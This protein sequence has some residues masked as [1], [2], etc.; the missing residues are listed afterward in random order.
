MTGPHSVARILCAGVLVLVAGAASAQVL[1]GEIF[2]KVSD[3]TDAVLPGATVTIAGPALIKPMAV[4]AASSG[5]YRFPNVPVGTYTM[6]FELPGFNK[7]VREGIIVQA[8]RNV[9]IN[10][11]LNLSTLEETVTITGASPVVDTKSTTLGVNFG[12]ELLEAIPTARDPWVII[13]QTPGLVMSANNVGGRNSGQ[14]EGYNAFGSGANK[15]WSMDGATVT[16]MASNSAPTYYDF[17]M[18]EEIQIQTGGMDASQ[19]SGGVSVNMVTRSGG[20]QLKGSSR[21]YTVDQRV[22]SKNAP[23]EVVAQGG[24]AG[25]PLKNN[26]EYGVEVG[27][28]IRRN[29]A[30]FWGSASNQKV[31]VGILGFLRPGAPA[32][33]SDIKDLNDDITEINNQSAKLQY[34]WTAAQ[35]STFLFQRSDK[36]RNARGASPTVALESTS[37]QT[38]PT[39]YF[40]YNHQW[41]VN[42]RLMLSGQGLFNGGGFLLNYH[43]DE[44]ATVQRLNHETLGDSRSGT[45][46]DNHRPTWEGR[47]DGNYFLAGFLGGDHSTKFGM[48]YRLTPVKTIS[49]TGGGATVRLRNNGDH[50]VNITRDGYVARDTWQWS[51]YFNDSWKMGRATL[52]W[53]LR[54]DRQDDKALAAEID[55]N[56]IL[57]DL[58]PAVGF[59]GADAGVV[60]NDIAPRLGFPYDLFGNTR[61]IFKA[62]AGR[63]Y[64][65]GLS[66]STDLS[67]TG[68]TTLS[69]W[70][71]DRNGD[72]FAQ[73][74]EIEF[75][76]GFRSTPTSNYD[77]LNPSAVRTPVKVDP[78]IENDITDEFITGIDHELMP[79]F[80]VGVSYVY[81]KYHNFQESFRDGITS[82]AYFHSGSPVTFTRSCGNALCDE[83]SYTGTYYQ[84]T[85]A[86]PA[87][88]TTRMYGGRTVYHGIEVT[89]RKRF[90]RNW[91]LNS[92]FSFNNTR[93]FDDVNTFATGTSTADPTNYELQNGRDNAG[94]NGARWLGKIAGMYALPW[95]MSMSAFYNVREGL[96]FNRTIQSPSRTG[97]GGTVNVRVDPQGTLH[98]PVH[99]QLDVNWDKTVTFGS[100]TITFSA[101][102][103][104]MLNASTV[105]GRE[106]R[107]DFARANFVTSILAPRIFRFG[108]KVKF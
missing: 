11:K 36:A 42:D 91:L 28:P 101:T 20:N 78:N 92:S 99:K 29:K 52:N 12:T 27:G 72:L 39:E 1:N 81:R 95:N 85:A 38:G 35:K 61:T 48:R 100:R 44:L 79:N 6:T 18:F 64:G 71:K 54:W 53:G 98:Y 23:S 46:S 45:L 87:A 70:W 9:E 47:L 56:P 7:V 22:Q 66:I 24:G 8:G 105:L 107:Q 13:E 41:V 96:Q 103:F 97:S 69:Y 25:N 21:I 3:Q 19:E 74:D 65:A 80:G 73:R 83:P 58:L 33:S 57:P 10:T 31:N 106:T 86:L 63:Y 68:Q 77:P 75:N 14:M 59:D 30:W 50:E 93:R 16:D 90:S 102:G 15:Q 67:P 4:V 76:R 40:N 43:N 84:R 89:G 88:S 5:G 62:S 49:K 108:A 82:D 17:D 34:Q 37:R 2:G 60:S 26:T 94:L 51:L 104:N 32:G 55:A